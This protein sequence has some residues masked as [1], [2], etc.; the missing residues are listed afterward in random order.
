[1]I[2]TSGFVL[3]TIA[4]QKAANFTNAPRSGVP[5]FEKASTNSAAKKLQYFTEAQ[6]C[7]CNVTIVISSSESSTAP[8]FLFG[9][10]SSLAGR[11]IASKTQLISWNEPIEVQTRVKNYHAHAEVSRFSTYS[12]AHFVSTAKHKEHKYNSY[13]NT[14]SDNS[15]RARVQAVPTHTQTTAPTLLQ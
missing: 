12:G 2:S 1:M 3:G 14:S 6:W 8:R 11:T 10:L 15:H 9:S 13:T 4:L 5:N 7:T